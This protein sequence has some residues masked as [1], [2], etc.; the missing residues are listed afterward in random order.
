MLKSSTD[1]SFQT[2]KKHSKTAKEADFRFLTG[3]HHRSLEQERKKETDRRSRRRRKVASAREVGEG[4][5]GVQ[6]YKGAGRRWYPELVMVE[7]SWMGKTALSYNKSAIITRLRQP[8][9]DKSD[10][11][12][13]KGASPL[14]ERTLFIRNKNE[15]DVFVS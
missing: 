2:Q 15:K 10:P 9:L 4:E 14:Q 7:T 8:P 13:F 12:R 5:G 3:S 11:R 1:T 6:M